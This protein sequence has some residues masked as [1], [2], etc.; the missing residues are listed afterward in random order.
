MADENRVQLG[1]VVPNYL[2]D[3]NPNLVDD[4]DMFTKVEEDLI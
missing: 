2:V 4:A 3:W 1:R